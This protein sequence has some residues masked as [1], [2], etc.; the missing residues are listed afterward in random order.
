MLSLDA[1]CYHVMSSA[2]LRHDS[3]INANSELHVAFQSHLPFA[4]KSQ[5]YSDAFSK[6]SCVHSIVFSY[7]SLIT[8][9]LVNSR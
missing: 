6:S 8:N 7:F 3:Q 2:T 1:V 5:N 9:I 4:R